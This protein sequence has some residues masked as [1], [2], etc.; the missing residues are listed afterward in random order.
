MKHEYNHRQLMALTFCASL[1]PAIRLMPRYSAEAAGRLCWLAPLLALPLLAAYALM[2]SAYLSRRHEGEGLGELILRTCGRAFGGTVLVIAAMFLVFCGGFILRSGAERFIRTVYPV[3]SPWMFV[4]VMLVLGLIAALG[5]G[6]ALIRSAKIF[7]PLL[8]AVIVTVLIFMLPELDLK[9][10]LPVGETSAE[11]L[12]KAAVPMLELYAGMIAYTAVYEGGAPKDSGRGRAEARR[13]I[14][15][16]LLFSVLCLCAVGCYGAPMTARFSHPFFAMIRNVTIFRTIEHIEAIV[17]ALW[18]LP[19][20]AVFSLMLGAAGR[21][22]MLTVGYKPITGEARLTDMKNGRWLIPV[23]AGLSAA[24]AV[25]IDLNS[26]NLGVFSE[27]YVPMS[28][29]LVVLVLIPLCFVVC[30]LRKG[31]PQ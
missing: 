21:L 8:C 11:G 2:L 7:A 6:K 22:L 23:C 14:P 5:P 18:V 1:A 9:L 31:G 12:L 24:W 30:L 20:F 13:C 17:V 15:V 28:N 4:A 29:M 19:D 3:A 10:L 27:L 25:I 16:C 26:Q